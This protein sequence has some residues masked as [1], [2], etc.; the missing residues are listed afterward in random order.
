MKRF[1]WMTLALISAALLAPGSAL[2]QQGGAAGDQYTEQI[3]TAGPDE[4]GSGVTGNDDG[5]SAGGGGNETVSNGDTSA[6]GSSTESG[7]GSGGSAITSDTANKFQKDPDGE[8][9]AGLAQ[10]GAPDSEALNE[11]ALRAQSG[12]D[13]TGS[14]TFGATTA[15]DDGGPGVGLLILAIVLAATAALGAIYWLWRRRQD[16]SPRTGEG[17]P[18]TA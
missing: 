15:E 17:S 6:G 8:A 10:S 2:A 1:K 13:D 7:A 16:R 9:A 14:S 3:P 5:G 12:A 4:T 18:S 11:A